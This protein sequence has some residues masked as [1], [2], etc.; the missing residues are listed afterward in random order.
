MLQN[1]SEVD[2]VNDELNKLLGGEITSITL[3]QSEITL[4][5]EGTMQLNAKVELTGKPIEPIE[6]TVKNLLLQR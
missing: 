2:K 3:D 1:Q 6:G 4:E 5:N